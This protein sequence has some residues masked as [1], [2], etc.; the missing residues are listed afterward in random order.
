MQETHTMKVGAAFPSKW[1]KADDLAGRDITVTIE[2][3]TF[4]KV[5]RDSQYIVYFEGKRKGLIMYE[6]QARQIANALGEDEMDSWKGREITL[7]VGRSD[8]GKDYIYVREQGAVDTRQ[9]QRAASAG[10]RQGSDEFAP[11]FESRVVARQ[12][13]QKPQIDEGDIPF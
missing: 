12:Q 7:Y 1:L 5:G 9:H 4:E 10:G 8:N 2:E 11:N 6:K 13:E 3:V